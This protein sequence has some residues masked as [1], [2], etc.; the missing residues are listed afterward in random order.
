MSKLLV[1]LGA[2]GQQGGSVI[3]AVLNDPQLSNQYRIR[4]LTRDSSKPAAKRLVE[5]GIEVI[6]GDLDDATSLQALFQSADTVF[7]LTETVH[8]EQ[9]KTRDYNRGKAL[10]NAAI[11][12]NVQFFIYS[13]QPHIAKISQGKFKHGEHVDVKAEVEDY[14]RAQP[15][16][17]AFVAPGSFMQIFQDMMAPVPINDGTYIIS[18]VVTPETKLPMLDAAEYTGKFIAAILAEPET[19]RN[20]TVPAATK[21]YSMEEIAQIMSVKSGKTIR[22]NQLPV[23]KFKKFMPPLIGD[24]IVDMMLYIQ[25]FGYYGPD[26]QKIME[27]TSVV[28]RG[29]LSSMESFFEKHGVKLR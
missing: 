12:A 14:I 15:I 11:A 8:D 24:R 13:T 26:T 6:Q 16:K 4:T 9:M 10:V 23:V 17:S 20:Q 29:E 1:V 18:S 3:N 25:D 28:A 21:L 5:N 7:A 19:Y 22:Y 27:R 2:T